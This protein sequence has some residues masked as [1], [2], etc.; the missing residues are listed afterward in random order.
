MIDPLFTFRGACAGNLA[1]LRTSH[2]CTQFTVFG[3]ALS[4]SWLFLPNA[5]NM[6]CSA[7]S[8]RCYSD[9]DDQ[10]SLIEFPARFGRYSGRR[11]GIEKSWRQTRPIAR[12]LPGS[13]LASPG[14]TPSPRHFAAVP[15]RVIPSSLRLIG[16]PIRLWRAL[17]ALSPNVAYF[18]QDS[19]PR[20]TLYRQASAL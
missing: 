19:L 13:T 4:G 1:T 5:S 15:V 2:P 16:V 7:Y 12:L 18:M 8:M 9:P 3:R 6:L 20:A 14:L 17:V 10:P 11:F